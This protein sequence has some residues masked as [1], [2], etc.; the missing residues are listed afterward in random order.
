MVD[1]GEGAR[2][3]PR[4]FNG[5]QALRHFAP[6]FHGEVD[7][8][9]D[10]FAR[11]ASLRMPKSTRNGLALF[12]VASVLLACSD[13]KNGASLLDEDCSAARK[14]DGPAQVRIGGR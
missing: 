5:G 7:F 8:W 3:V 2:I 13:G 12:G 4:C 9:A 11:F 6:G 14:D 1:P 10:D